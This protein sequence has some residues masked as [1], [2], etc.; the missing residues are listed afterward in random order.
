MKQRNVRRI[1]GIAVTCAAVAVTLIFL[2]RPIRAACGEFGEYLSYPFIRRA[3]FAGLGVSLCASLLGVSLVLKRYSM[4]GDGLSHVGFGALSVA[5]ALGAV[6]A[7]SRFYPIAQQI[8]GHPTLFTTLVVTVLAF[9]LLR[10]SSSARMKGDAAI[11]VLS[12]GALALGVIVIS[13]TPGMNIDLSGY[14]FGSILSVSGEDVIWALSLSGVCLIL[15]ILFYARIFAVT[16]DETFARATGTRAGLINMLLATLTAVTVVM[17]MRLMGTMLIS[18]LILFP[19]L[20]AMRISSRFR[21]VVICSA[22][23]SV[24]CFLA[25]LF[26]S[27][28]WSV[29]TGAAVIAANVLALAIASLCGLRGNAAR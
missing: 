20:T 22:L 12:T 26:V 14:L 17:G 10:M 2:R 9:A 13:C 19:P 3:L 27:C 16:F 29:P 7:A 15:Y 25:G 21:R 4:I 28:I 8:S 5:M 1:T 6:P 23:V 18:G 11:A 24:V